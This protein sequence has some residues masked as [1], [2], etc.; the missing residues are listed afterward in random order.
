MKQSKQPR[1]DPAL[2]FCRLCREG[3]LFEAEAWLKAGKPAQYE[4]RNVRCTPLGIAIDRNF[5]SLVE[6]LLRNGFQPSAKHLWMAVSRGKVGILELLLESGADVRWLDLRQVVFWRHPDVLRLLIERGADTRTGYPIAEAL[7][8]APRGFLGVFKAYIGRFPDWQ[9]QADMALRHFCRE[10]SMRGVCLLLWLKA[11][12]RAKVPS[13]AGDE[14]DTWESGLWQAC[15]NGHVEIVKKIGPKPEKDDL[16]ELLRLACYGQNVGLIEYLVGL[17][18]NPNSVPANGETALRSALWALE[19]RLDFDRRQAYAYRYRNALQTLKALIQSG[20]RLN[21][22]SPE[23][24]RF[25]RRC[26][27]KLDW[28]ESYDLIKFLHEQSFADRTVFVDLLKVPKM[29][30]HLAQRLPALSRIFPE[31]KKWVERNANA[32]LMRR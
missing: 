17:G 21:P 13:E 14:P 4:H 6:V 1:D 12:P 15:I 25:L 22:A 30:Q 18:A 9:F 23:E 20:A 5:H 10:G 29:R 3:R 26:F 28:L 8:R 31:L 2:E 16:D 19:W 27:L 32:A 24:I 7:K 11:D